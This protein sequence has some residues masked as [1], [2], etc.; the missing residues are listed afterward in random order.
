MAE[1][2]AGVCEAVAGGEALV[3][4]TDAE[5]GVVWS[6]A[7]SPASTLARAFYAGELDGL[8]EGLVLN[9]DQAGICVALVASRA[10][11]AAC[12]ARRMSEPGLATFEAH[13]IPVTYEELIP[14]VR[15]SKNEAVVCPIEAGLNEC[16]NEDAR[17]EF[18]RGRFGTG[19]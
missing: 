7:A 10:G 17:W 9:S 16:P 4:L 11:F 2:S 1:A 12:H 3:A 13:G 14:L 5:G 6:S 15:S 8:G 18:M 19:A